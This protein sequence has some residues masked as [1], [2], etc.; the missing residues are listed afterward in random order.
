MREI[1]GP[2]PSDPE[3]LEGYRYLVE[4]GVV[5]NSILVQPG[6]VWWL[7]KG[8]VIAPHDGSFRVQIQNCTYDG[9][10]IGDVEVWH[11]STLRAKLEQP[12]GWTFRGVKSE[13][14]K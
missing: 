1:V 11:A 2:I 5:E 8:F 13:R 12:N 9:T 3:E 14:K 7:I 4:H 6:G 10:P